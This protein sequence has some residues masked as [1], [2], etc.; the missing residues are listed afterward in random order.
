MS[1]LLVSSFPCINS[2]KSHVINE[3]ITIDKYIEDVKKGTYINHIIDVRNALEQHGKGDQYSDAKKNLPLVTGCCTIKTGHSRGKSNIEK[4]NGLIVID[5]DEDVN[6]ELFNDISND[7][8]TY[9]AHRSAGGKGVCIFV[10]INTKKF[11]ESFYDLAQYYLD[12]YE[13]SIDQ[14]CKDEARARFVSYDPYIFVNDNSAKFVS[15]YKKPKEQPKKEYLFAEDDFGRI[16]N[17]LKGVDLCQGEYKRYCDIGFAIAS[18]FGQSGFHYYDAICHGGQ[19]YDSKRIERDY[20]RFCKGGN[21]GITIATLYHY[22]KESG[23]DVVSESTKNAIEKVR[24]SKATKKEILKPT[25][26]ELQIIKIGDSILKQDKGEDLDSKVISFIS[27]EWQ[28]MFNEFNGMIEVLESQLDDR[29]LN[30]MSIQSSSYCE[31]DVTPQR[32]MKCLNSYATSTKNKVFDFLEKLEYKGEGYIKNYVD[33]IE[34]KKDINVAYFTSWMVGMMNNIHRR[35][36]SDKIS[37][38]T[39]VLAGGRQGIGKST[40]CR[41]ILPK[42]FEDYFVEGKIEETK[43]FKFRMCRNI[44]MYDDEFGGVGSKDVK[45]FKSVSDMSVAV[46]RKAY[47]INDSREL[48]KVSL[49]G[50]T[51]ELDILKDPTGNRRILPIRVES[52]KYDECLG[53]DSKA[54]LAEAYKLW[55]DGFEWVIRKEEDL[56]LMKSENDEF[57]ENDEMEDVFFDRFS[58]EPTE[59]YYIKILLNKGEILKIFSNTNLKFSK[60]DLRKIY[61]RNNMKYDNFIY[62]GIKKKSFILYQKNNFQQSETGEPPF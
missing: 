53:F 9:I 27:Q 41:Q 34:P 37:P 48:R 31:Q 51:N 19:K 29:T 14:A 39:I 20:N 60:Y 56:N 12:N 45:N 44:I 36:I 59:E 23:I 49:L 24:I 25:D 35:R 16:I 28:P 2:K 38:L 52:I 42:E 5:I 40:W 21:D 54:L 11:L 62:D 22:A 10:K 6:D 18:K 30:T 33:L 1:N 43:D 55:K 57:Y 58:L 13:V 50:S 47:G 4:M 15:T 46:D 8:Y 61:I 26:L 17:D 7:K 3:N 32:V